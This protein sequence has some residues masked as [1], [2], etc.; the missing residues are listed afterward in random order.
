MRTTADR[1]KTYRL[2]AVELR[3][4][5]DSMRHAASREAFMRMARDYELMADHLEFQIKRDHKAH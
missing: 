4:A 2:R 1:A 5:G 3:A